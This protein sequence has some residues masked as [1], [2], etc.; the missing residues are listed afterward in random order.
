MFF[1][2]VAF[3]TIRPESDFV[4]ASQLFFFFL[5]SVLSSLVL[6]PSD[7]RARAP[8]LNASCSPADGLGRRRGQRRRGA[9]ES[10]RRTSPGRGDALDRAV[11]FRF[12]FF[13]ELL[14][15]LARALRGRRSFWPRLSGGGRRAPCRGRGA[16]PRGN[17]GA[18]GGGKRRERMNG[19]EQEKE[20]IGKA[21]ASQG[22]KDSTPS[23]PRLASRLTPTPL[24]K[25]FNAET[26]PN[27][28]RS[29]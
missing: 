11:A 26:N 6:S 27:S 17:A 25:F 4:E 7:A 14:V 13:F 20:S 21:A 2:L 1:F 23:L 24:I 10:Q 9:R 8:Y 15:L 18:G 16:G 19:K 28:S 3:P 5:F 29:R 12:R 22:S